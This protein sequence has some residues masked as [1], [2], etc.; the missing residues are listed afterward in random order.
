VRQTFERSLAEA[1]LSQHRL[2]DLARRMSGL[3]GKDYNP[4]DITHTLIALD[5]DEAAGTIDSVT[6]LTI[7]AEQD[8]VTAADFF[9]EKLDEFSVE[10]GDGHVLAFEYDQI[11]G[12]VSVDLP[13]ELGE[14]DDVVLKF[15]NS[16]EPNCE[17]DPYFGMSFCQVSE[18][19]VFFAI[20]DWVP[21]MAAS[22]YIGL[23]T[24]GTVDFDI[25]TPA[26]YVAV[27]TSDP[28]G[29]DEIGGGL[30]HHFVGHF[31]D[32]G[33]AGMAYAQY[34]T[35]QSATGD[36]EPVTT[37]LHTGTED[38]AQQWADICADVID[39]YGGIF[40][41]YLYNKQDVI[42][43]I[44]E[45]GGGVG[46]QSATFYYASALNTSPDEF[47]SESIFSHEIAHSWW[48]NMIRPGEIYSPWLSE[49]FA[50]YSSRLFGYQFGEA[51]EVDY[52]YEYYFHVFQFY[53]DPDEEVP[54]TGPRIFTDDS[55]IYFLTTYDKGAHFLRMLQWLLGDEDFF[56]AL[57]DYA[58]SHV[59][60]NTEQA[61]TVDAFREALEEFS[62]LDL[63][64][65]FDAWVYNTGYPVYRWAAQF[66]EGQD[67]YTV[68]LRVVQ[69]QDSET[70]YDIPL[71]VRIRVDGEDE[72]R[73]FIIEFNGRVADQTFALDK[74]PTKIS[75]DGSYWVWGDKVPELAGDVDGSNDVDG[76]D[77]IYTAW[78][79]GGEILSDGGSYNY[80]S[81]ADF[82]RDGKTNDDD[83]TLLLDNF[84]SKGAIND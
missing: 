73:T 53:V 22:D 20:A 35:F 47:Y 62:G 42:Q 57:A 30:L 48:A 51:W 64:Q 63:T 67:G 78:S 76:L 77:L 66:G 40:T 9:I 4:I 82:N 14:G 12:L 15:F 36:D 46:P 68:R 43:T 1:A 32:W 45:L 31:T 39:F 55:T 41:P 44:E 23:Y 24:S 83:L 69:D 49:G 54:L 59:W 37:Y 71:E 19:I 6:T 80:L 75:V 8:G 70:V 74:Q 34:D 60:D 81:Q 10:D 21:T 13:A 61:V 29:I 7:E 17:P 18:E 65:F 5:A 3:K 27:T 84:A 11:N 25:T 16:G 79:Q 56:A 38:Y 50:E 26:G 52:V 28:A 58:E 2:S 72:P 33:G